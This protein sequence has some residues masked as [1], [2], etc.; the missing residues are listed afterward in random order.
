REDLPRRDHVQELALVLLAREHDLGRN[1]P[2]LEALLALID[3]E[4]EEVQ[5]GDPLDEPGL[6]ALPLARGDDAGHE[7]E[8]EDALGALFLAVDRER[9][10]LVHER[11]LLHALTRLDLT[12]GHFPYTTLFR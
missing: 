12:L 10:A 11:E 4:D 3:V 9:D 5:G 8:R 2:V 1:D 7:V 6:Q